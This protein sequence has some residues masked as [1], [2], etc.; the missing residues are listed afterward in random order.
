LLLVKG[1]GFSDVHIGN[2]IAIG[3]AEGAI[4]LE[5][6]LYTLEAA[7][8]EGVG[9]CVNQGYAPGLGFA[10]VNLHLV[11]CH[12]EGDIAGVEEVVRE[13]FLDHIALIAATYNEIVD[14]MRGIDFQNVPENRK[15]A[16]LHHGLGANGGFFADPSAEPSGQNN[17]LHCFSYFTQEIER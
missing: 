2:A 9:T 12:V 7:A 16:D 14:T 3:E 8:G 5:V 17:S 6:G 10:V 11:G 1:E 15:A 13:V 4:A